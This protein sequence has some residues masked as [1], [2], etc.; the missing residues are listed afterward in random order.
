L[1]VTGTPGVGKTTVSAILAVKLG[2][3]HLDIATL[4]KSAHLTK[5]YD[6]K[7]QTLIADTDRLAQRVQQIMSKTSKS[8]IVDGH[9]STDVVPAKQVTRVF[10]LRCHPEELRNRMNA[11]GFQGSKVKENLAAEILDVCLADAIANV[12][13]DKVCEIDTTRQTADASASQI[14]SIL[15][16]RKRCVIRIVDWLGRLEGEGSLDQYL[17]D[18]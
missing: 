3:L 10:V 6:K 2:G 17:K 7:R 16:G 4:V 18:F 14:V 13:E 1:V 5:G 9:Y 11:R 12:G 8:L 15:R